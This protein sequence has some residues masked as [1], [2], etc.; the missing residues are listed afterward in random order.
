LE[1][2]GEFL[3]QPQAVYVSHLALSRAYKELTFSTVNTRVGKERSQLDRSN[4]LILFRQFGA[5]D[6]IRTRA[7]N[8]GKVTFSVRV[9]GVRIWPVRCPHNFY[10]SGQLSKRQIDRR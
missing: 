2:R 6:A 9:T 8:L 3:T 5:G 7:P 10:P 4:R 1:G